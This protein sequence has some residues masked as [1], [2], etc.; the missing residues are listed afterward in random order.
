MEISLQQNVTLSEPCACLVLA[1]HEKGRL[2]ANAKKIDELS[3]GFLSR[4]LASG[5]FTAEPGQCQLLYGIP[6]LAAER[7]LLVGVGAGDRLAEGNLQKAARALGQTV[8]RAQLT[9]LHLAVADVAVAQRSSAA[10]TELWLRGILDA[11]YRFDQHKEPAKH[12]RRSLEKISVLVE[13]KMGKE[14]EAEMQL[15]LGYANAISRASDWARDLANQPGNICTPTWLAEQASQMARARG[16]EAEILGPAEMEELGM[17]LLLGV[18]Q[19]SRQEPRLIVLHYRGGAADAAPI[20]L[21]GKGLT[22]DAGGISLKPA[23]KMDEMK[24]DMCGGAA[25]LAAIQ[26]A[27]DLALPLNVTVI[28]PASENLPDG[29]ATKPGDIHRSMAG[30]TVEIINTDAEGRLILADALSYAK[31]FNPDVVI[32]MATLTGACI[33]ALGHQTAAVLGNHQGLVAELLHAGRSSQDRAWELPLF[34]EYQEQ[35]KSPF[36][37][38]SNV[39]GRPAGTITAACFLS[40]FTEEYRWAHLDI[41]GVAWQSGEH[42]GATGRPVP[43]LVHFLLQRAKAI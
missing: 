17:Q 20:V 14:E 28:V 29:Q 39:G 41:A 13:G 12:P 38:L 16:I 2:T 10:A 24:Y 32:D 1:C 6:G 40:R 26:A 27:A 34:D 42:R 9:E 33:I 18:A 43:L 3:G 7:L 31:R 19:G 35:L 25:A 21:V 15:A 8:A 23:D 37:D 30:L 11:Q 4:F 22:F 36:A 5:D